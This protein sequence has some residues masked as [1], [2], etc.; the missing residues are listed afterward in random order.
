MIVAFAAPAFAA[1]FY[2]AQNAADKDLRLVRV[3]DLSASRRHDR[4]YREEV[5]HHLRS[6]NPSLRIDHGQSLSLALERRRHR[7]TVDHAPGI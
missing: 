5:T 1:E 7:P 4:R 2:A 3:P 6:V